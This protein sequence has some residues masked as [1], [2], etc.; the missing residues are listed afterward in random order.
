VSGVRLESAV[1]TVLMKAYTP[2]K[3]DAIGTAHS[4]RTYHRHPHAASREDIMQFGN[5]SI[6]LALHD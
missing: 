1:S 3:A 5:F 6:S 2:F 4:S